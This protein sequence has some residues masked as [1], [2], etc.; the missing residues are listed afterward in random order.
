[1]RLF[2]FTC[3]MYVFVL[4]LTFMYGVECVNENLFRFCVHSWCENV[5]SFYAS[6]TVSE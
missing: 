1:M 4:S 6:R 2:L 3:L 5:D